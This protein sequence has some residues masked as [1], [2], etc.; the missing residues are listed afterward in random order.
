MQQR[1]QQRT[2]TML[3]CSRRTRFESKLQGMRSFLLRQTLRHTAGGQIPPRCFYD[4]PIQLLGQI[5]NCKSSQQLQHDKFLN[6]QT[7][8]FT[9]GASESLSLTQ[10]HHVGFTDDAKLISLKQHLPVDIYQYLR[11]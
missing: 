11:E 1:M 2:L 5:R 7:N 10:V 4:S 9:F 6:T 3:V 8:L